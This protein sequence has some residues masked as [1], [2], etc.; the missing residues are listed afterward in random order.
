M[1]GTA[2]DAAPAVDRSLEVGADDERGLFLLPEPEDVEYVTRRLHV[3]ADYLELGS[4]RK[5]AK[6][7]GM[8][9]RTV[10]EWLNELGVVR[11]P[12]GRRAKRSE[13]DVKTRRDIVVALHAR[14]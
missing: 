3:A 13:L 4:M 12:S 1:R 6:L 7:R 8:S 10:L 14:G 5:V 9:T 11:Y 2:G